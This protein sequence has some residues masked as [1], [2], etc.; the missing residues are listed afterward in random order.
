M[1]FNNYPVNTIN[2]KG[3]VVKVVPRGDYSLP[4]TSDSQISNKNFYYLIDI[5]LIN[6][7]NSKVS[8]MIYNCS[9]TE[10]FIVNTTLA[11]I[12]FNNCSKNVLT[13]IDLNPKQIYTVPLLLQVHNNNPISN[14]KV[15]FFAVS[16]SKRDCFLD[17]LIRKRNGHREV[18]WSGNFNLQ[19]GGGTIYEI[20]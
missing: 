2:D 15:G 12:C 14:V 3:L 9:Y 4:Q 13:Q 11:E 16:P 7:S 8:F 1:S 20:E 17:E 6:N 10:C 5:N 18:I 19:P